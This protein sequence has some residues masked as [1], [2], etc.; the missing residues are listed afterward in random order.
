MKT[1]TKPHQI[2]DY[3]TSDKIT[4]D[5]IRKIQEA[6]LAVERGH[7]FGITEFYMLNVIKGDPENKIL[8]AVL[9]SLDD[10][11]VEEGQHLS[12]LTV[13]V[14]DSKFLIQKYVSNAL[15]M[16]TDKCPQKCSYCFRK[17]HNSFSITREDIDHLIEDLKKTNSSL[18]E[19][20]ITGGDPLYV[21][22]DLL[23][24]LADKLNELN[25]TIGRRIMIDLNTRMPIVAPYLFDD[26]LYDVIR[27]LGIGSIGLHIIHPGEITDEFKEVCMNLYSLNP[28]PLSLRTVHP[29]LK[30]INDDAE[31]L[32]DLY[33]RLGSELHVVPKDLILPLTIGAGAEKRL[34]LDRGMEIARELM[35]K[36]PGQLLPKLVVCS[37]MYG[38][39]YVDPFHQKAD[40]SFG[41]DVI[42]GH[43]IGL[44]IKDGSN[45]QK[46]L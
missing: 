43:Y 26:R 24:Y 46:E 29:M 3:F 38:K 37:P 9:P 40:G 5:L 42:K 44:M 23:D 18:V 20:I 6:E 27:K 1:I 32:I 21:K 30:G 22:I 33:R 7:I 4:E 8:N 31:I 15:I 28:I 39:S 13:K 14:S 34:T 35:M 12:E 45:S 19:L 11:V 2:L 36:L 17:N 41:Y 10:L 16:I 25:Q